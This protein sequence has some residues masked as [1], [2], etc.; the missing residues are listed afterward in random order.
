MIYVQGGTFMMGCDVE[1]DSE[2]NDWETPSHQVTLSSYYIAETEVTRVLWKA[3][4]GRY[5]GK[6]ADDD[7]P[8]A[9]ISWGECQYFI[10]ILNEMTGK[11]FRMP[12]EAEW[13]YAARGGNKSKGYKYAG[14]DDLEEVAWYDMNSSY[15]THPIKSKKPNELGL[16]D[17]SGNVWEWC[18][19]C[20]GYYG[21][22]SQTDPAG[23][24]DGPLRVFRGG[25]WYYNANFCRVSSRLSGQTVA[26]FDD[27]GLR[28]V[29]DVES[30]K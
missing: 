3:V 20:Y 10:R 4:I 5:P 21:T 30:E 27:V 18:S 23:P 13:E 12:S 6:S 8:A 22:E 17:M 7:C 26:R 2:C 9:F 24:T 28:L 1:R 14:S 19:D 25:S 16:Y 11:T 15:K 29:L